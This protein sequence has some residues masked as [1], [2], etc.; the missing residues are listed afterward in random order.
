MFL[1]PDDVILYPAF[2]NNLFLLRVKFLISVS[3]VATSV[4]ADEVFLRLVFDASSLL[5]T[6]LPKMDQGALICRKKTGT[7]R[8]T[9]KPPFSTSNE[10]G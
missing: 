7:T 4:W 9:K 10:A 3:I 2:V 1:I 5:A 6:C 8:S